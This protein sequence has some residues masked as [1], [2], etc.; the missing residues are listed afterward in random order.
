MTR[1]FNPSRVLKV[2]TETF[3]MGRAAAL[4]AVLIIS[5]VAVLAIF[6]FIR[7]AP[8]TSL[9]ITSGPPGSG[10]QTNAEKYR[11]ILAR[12]GVKLHNLPSGGS[13]ENL[14]RLTAPNFRVDVG[15]V[16]GGMTNPAGFDKLVSLGSLSYQSLLVFYR[17]TT[18]VDLLSGL[19]G[20]R[21]SVGPLGSGARTLAL[22]LLTTNG[23]TTNGTALLN[24][25]ADE[26]S[27]GLLDG[28]LD[29]VFLMGDSA[30]PQIMRKLLRAPGVQLLSFTQADAY[31]RRF[32]YLNK[33]VLP[34]GSIDFGRNIP[35]Q[36]VHLIGPTVELVARADL[37]PA[38]SDLLLEAAREVHGNASLF[39]RRGEFPAPLEHDIP[40]SDDALRYYKSGKTFFY[41]HLPF[42]MASLISRILVVF[43]PAVVVL[44]PALRLIPAVY[45]WRMRTRIYRWYRAL[46]VLEREPVTPMTPGQREAMLR[47]LDEIEQAATRMK[48]PASFGD[49]FYGLR[50]HI[51]LVRD[52]LKQGATGLPTGLK[53]PPPS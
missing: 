40:I 53:P 19:A 25:D 18:T 47:Q 6:F 5:L 34:M 51:S 28:T 38:L 8:P 48:V 39:Q 23:I 14:E 24:H 32:R 17:G 13:L 36:D 30:S 20:K 45:R 42:W 10:F 43:I 52:R 2:F 4:A 44:I 49:Q 9:I 41:R 11:V 33:L 7:S 29:A 22:T 31:A 16:Q 37:H 27:K 3:G 1:K 35:A 12:N 50:S 46:L 15:F 21:I 26:A